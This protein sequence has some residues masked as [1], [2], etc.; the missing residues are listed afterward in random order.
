MPQQRE[1]PKLDTGVTAF[2]KITISRVKKENSRQSEELID[3]TQRFMNQATSHLATTRAQHG[4]KREVFSIGRRVEQEGLR[5]EK[6]GVFE[7]QP[8][9]LW[10]NGI[11]RGLYHAALHTHVSRSLV[12]IWTFQTVLKSHF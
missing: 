7:V 9:I 3:F 11:C 5:G 8:H 6:G 12:L 1:G 4:T 2:Y 10:G